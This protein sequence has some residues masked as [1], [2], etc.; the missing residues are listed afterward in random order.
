LRRF[1]AKDESL[2]PIKQ[3]RGYPLMSQATQSSPQEAT[4]AD[5]KAFVESLSKSLDDLR[6]TVSAHA[7][8]FAQSVNGS[9]ADL[10]QATPEEAKD[11]VGSLHSDVNALR[12]TIAGEV[13]DFVGSVNETAKGMQQTAGAGGASNGGSSDLHKFGADV[14]SLATALDLGGGAGRGLITDFAPVTGATEPGASS[15]PLDAARDQVDL[16]GAGDLRRTLTQQAAS[17]AASSYG[18]HVLDLQG[19]WSSRK[20]FGAGYDGRAA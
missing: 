2:N 12:Q 11:F 17:L 9:V 13:K 18:D 4:T 6:Q 10:Q 20:M 8:N 16:T 14:S 1:A 15:A 5:A 7:D 3:N 19:E